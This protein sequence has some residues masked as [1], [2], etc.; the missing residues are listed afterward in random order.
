MHSCND[1]Y[2]AFK[3]AQRVSKIDGHNKHFKLTFIFTLIVTWHKPYQQD[4]NINLKST[5]PAEDM[6]S[7]WQK[8]EIYPSIFGH[9]KLKMYSFPQMDF[10]NLS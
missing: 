1:R 6:F 3:K 7:V 10:Y 2:S 8:N 9:L 4:K 5:S